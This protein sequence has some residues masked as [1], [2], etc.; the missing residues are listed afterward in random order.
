MEQLLRLPYQLKVCKM[1]DKNRQIEGQ[2]GD[3]VYYL[4]MQ[5]KR[6]GEE[7]IQHEYEI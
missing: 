2:Y 7:D 6:W 3:I 4:R 1:Q 5:T